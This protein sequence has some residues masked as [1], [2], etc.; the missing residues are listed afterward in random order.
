MISVLV[1]VVVVHFSVVTLREATCEQI[2]VGM[3]WIEVIGT[4]LIP[5]TIPA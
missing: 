1:K 5:F 4:W 2:E 3:R